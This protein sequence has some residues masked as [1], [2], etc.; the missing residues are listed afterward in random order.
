[1]KSAG[2]VPRRSSS[3]IFERIVLL[4]ERHGSAVEPAV[5]HLRYPCHR[6]AADRT[7]EMDVIHIWSVKL[8]ILGQYPPERFST[9]SALLPMH[10]TMS[11]FASPDRNQAYPSI[12][13]LEIAQSL[14][15]ASQLPNLLF[16]DEVRDT[17]LPC[18]CLPPAGPSASSFRYTSSASR[19]RPAAFRISSSADSYAPSS[20][21]AKI[22][23]S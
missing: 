7:C 17:S 23:S 11:A 2:K 12:C 13:L 9:S 18:C 19:S 6:L 4:R 3:L 20:I 14:T 16:A 21:F 5:H 15:S 22:L 10:S 8:D 1:M